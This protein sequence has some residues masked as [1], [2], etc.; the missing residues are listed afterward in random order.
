MPIKTKE[1]KHDYMVSFRTTVGRWWRRYFGVLEEVFEKMA[2]MLHLAVPTTLLIVDS[3]P[4]SGLTRCG[5]RLGLRLQA[6]SS[7][8]LSCIGL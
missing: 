4:P 6:R 8:V 7:A 1:M 5:H 2:N 3:T